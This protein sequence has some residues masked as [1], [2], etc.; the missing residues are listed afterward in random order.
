MPL[1]LRSVVDVDVFEDLVSIY[2]V[3]GFKIGLRVDRITIAQCERVV[4]E[5]SPQRLPDGDILGSASQILVRILT[6][7]LPYLSD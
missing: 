6:M 4:V 1:M 3:L 5:R 2:N 7:S